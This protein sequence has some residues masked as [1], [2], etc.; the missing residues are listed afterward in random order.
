MS[1]E[2]HRDL[3]SLPAGLE[4][5]WRALAESRANAFITPDWARAWDEVFGEDAGPAV[6]VSR[7][8][9]GR[10]HGVMPMVATRGTGG[11]VLRFAGFN[12]GDVFHPACA[13]GEDAAVA[14]DCL[15]ALVEA[16]GAKAA[17]LDHVERDA[18]WPGAAVSAAGMA[19]GRAY[20][21]DVLPWIDLA[22]LDW[23]RFLASRSRNLRSQVRRKTRALARDHDAAFR[24]A[25]AETLGADLDALVALHER[26][27]QG[28]GGS[29]ALGERPR[30]FHERF[31]AAA[32]ERGW[33]R[34]WVLEL[35]G[36][37]A[38]ALYGW[39]LG[40]RFSYYQAGFDPSFERESVGM[41]LLA[42]TIRMATEEGALVY[43][44]LRGGETYKSRFADHE[45]AVHTVALAQPAGITRAAL[46]AEAAAWRA[47]RRLDPKQRARLAAAYR[48]AE[49]FM[50]GGR[51]R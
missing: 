17:L 18:A 5:E 49:R 40:D 1:A 13:P 30:R 38:A 34:L 39:R 28:R 12:L 37:A 3:A 32:L 8:T 2:V 25:R 48:R 47:S 10:V 6:A 23:E 31:A 44:L 16:T 35:R 43:D 45:R 9:S 29:G 51:S 36:E 24:A 26:R 21:D 15:P 7:D 20:R 46:G 41:V 33:L 50:P 14:A 22:G 19:L 27:W 4:D 11:T 42:H